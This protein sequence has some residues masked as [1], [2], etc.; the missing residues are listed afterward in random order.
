MNYF[1]FFICALIKSTIGYRP[2]RIA[3]NALFNKFT[4]RYAAADSKDYLSVLRYAFRAIKLINDQSNKVRI[5]N[6]KLL[7][8]DGNFKSKEDRISYLEKLIPEP[9]LQIVFRNYL[10]NDIGR[11]IRITYT[12]CLLTLAGILFI[13]SLFFKDKAKFGLILLE[14][15]EVL[16]LV[17]AAKQ[18]NVKKMLIFCA[19]ERDIPLI[20]LYFIQNG[21]EIGI[22]PS[23]N[24]LYPF[25][26][27]VI[28]PEFYF[29]AP[30]QK[31][32]FQLLKS[33]WIYNKTF[34][35]PP[36]GFDQVILRDPKVPYK[37]KIGFLSSAMF[38]RKRMNYAIGFDGI[39]LKTESKLIE[40]FNTAKFREI[41]GDSI[42]LIYLH[43]KEKYHLAQAKAIYSELLNVQFEFADVSRASR[44]LFVLCEL[45]L[46]G[47]S[48]SQ[49]ERLYGGFKTVFAQWE[50]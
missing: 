39:Q 14:L 45:T 40:F 49:F 9:D 16:L 17:N 5:K 29:T 37:Y 20:S 38:L 42:L 10:P 36:F 7:I 21:W 25:Y 47:F 6:D 50:N 4:Y 27:K 18:M 23:S 44:E 26:K 2:E 8:F 15:S 48:S 43:P 30:F 1:L 11:G 3:I 33:N 32:E 46:S 35:W 34:D 22:I 13:V 24:P 19:Y 12:F 31:N 41:L 28:C